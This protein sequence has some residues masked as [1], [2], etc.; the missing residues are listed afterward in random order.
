MELFSSNQGLYHFE[1]LN[2]NERSGVPASSFK[3]VL[4]FEKEREKSS[5]FDETTVSER[6]E[7][8]EQ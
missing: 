4:D 3:H 8:E 7:Q 2:S 1:L 6:L 5:H